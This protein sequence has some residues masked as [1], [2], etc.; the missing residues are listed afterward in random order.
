MAI[1]KVEH[2]SKTF[3]SSQI[4]SDISFSMEQGQTLSLIGSSGSGKTTLLRCLN[5]LE[6]P[7]EGRIRVNDEVIFDAG[8]TGRKTDKEIRKRRLHFGLVFQ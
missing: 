4:L 3:G 1:L 6:R 2:I 7:D 5:F 8:E